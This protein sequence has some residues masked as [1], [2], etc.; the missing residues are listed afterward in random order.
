MLYLLPQRLRDDHRI[1]RLWWQP[2]RASDAIRSHACDGNR[3]VSRAYTDNIH[4]HRDRRAS[5]L[6]RSLSR[7]VRGLL[8]RPVLDERLTQLRQRLLAGG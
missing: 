6:C 5:H 1:D 3:Y 2:D 8:V 4:P 7:F